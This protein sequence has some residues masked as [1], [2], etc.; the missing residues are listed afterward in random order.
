MKTW[1]KTDSA[2][3]GDS[4]CL[5]QGGVSRN[6][7]DRPDAPLM[8]AVWWF[9]ELVSFVAFAAAGTLGAGQGKRMG[10][11]GRGRFHGECTPLLTNQ[12]RNDVPR[13]RLRV[14]GRSSVH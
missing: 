5:F 11:P 8:R 3:H 4:C 6:G 12:A 14:G 10:V 1:Q 9:N 7:G 13:P 2:V